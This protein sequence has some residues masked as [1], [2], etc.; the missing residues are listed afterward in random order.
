MHGRFAVFAGVLVTALLIGVVALQ[1][2][3]QQT[4][5][6]TTALQTRLADL[7][8]RNQTLRAETARLSSPERVETWGIKAGM[9]V[10]DAQHTVILQV[11]APHGAQDTGVDGAGAG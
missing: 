9:R 6:H 3:L 4:S 10:P 5:F 1:V 7:T 2:T 8:H 11:R